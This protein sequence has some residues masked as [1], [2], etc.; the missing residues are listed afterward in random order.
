MKPV[1]AGLISLFILGCAQQATAPNS[2]SHVTADSEWTAL[3]AS[4]L[5][6]NLGQIEKNS[7]YTMRSEGLFQYT[8]LPTVD[9]KIRRLQFESP[10]KAEFY[11]QNRKMLLD[12]VFKNNIAP[13]FGVIEI[14][15]GC[16]SMAK[17]EARET[18][19]ASMTTFFMEFPMLNRQTI[20]DCVVGQVVGVMR[21]EFF[22]CRKERTVFELSHFRRKNEPV[23]VFKASCK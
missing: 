6:L 20:S 15:P 23:A 4:A 12:Q 10:D 17:T 19:T 2:L 7:D 8:Q 9:L 22:Y 5:R 13:Y 21:Y 18:K 11:L 3:P 14:D 16:F 1:I